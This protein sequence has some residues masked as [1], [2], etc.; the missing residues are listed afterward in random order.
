M[1]LSQKQINF[2]SIVLKYFDNM[3]IVLLRV[4][5]K[6]ESIKDIDL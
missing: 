6:N 3:L 4:F 1:F 2:F 5:C